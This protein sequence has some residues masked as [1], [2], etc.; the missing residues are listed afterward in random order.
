MLP[1]TVAGFQVRSRIG[2]WD[3]GTY[4]THGTYGNYGIGSGWSFF[5]HF[6]VVKNADRD[7]LIRCARGR[8]DSRLI[9]SFAIFAILRFCVMVLFSEIASWLRG[10]VVQSNCL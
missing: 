3:D 2:A 8:D 6:E 7:K 4:G 5:D 10:F 9:I 1:K